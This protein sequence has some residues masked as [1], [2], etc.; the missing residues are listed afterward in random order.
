[1]VKIGAHMSI[2]GG[3]LKAAQTAVQQYKATAFQCFLKSPRGGKEKE[4]TDEECS[5]IAAY[6]KQ[7]DLFAIVHCSYL[8][9]FAKDL[10]NP[11]NAYQLTSLVNDANNAGRM[12]MHGVVYHI[13]KT[14]D[15]NYTEAENYVVDN[16]IEACNL[17]KKNGYSPPFKGETGEIPK[18]DHQRGWVEGKTKHLPR[19]L[20]ETTAGQGTEIGYT[21][22]ALA[23]LYSKLSSHHDR[24]GIC[25]DTAHIWA[26]GHDISTPEAVKS[27][28]KQFDQ[29]IGLQHLDCIHLND[30][31]KS[32]GSRVDRHMDIGKGEIGLDGLKAVVEFANEQD[33]P[34]I[35]ETPQKEQTWQTEIQMVKSF[36]A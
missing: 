7:Q 14:L 21:L 25:V 32:L 27:Y 1:M 29:Q 15:L 35:L 13:G 12:G 31:R 4:F 28:F 33:I 23:K 34:C 5:Q 8:L 6:V 30:S 22:E 19:I 26:G 24:L 17:T 18:G 9:N 3:I 16:L 10:D 20:L 36:T 11:K 2:S